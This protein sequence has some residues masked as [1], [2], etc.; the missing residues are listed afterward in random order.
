MKRILHAAA[1][2][3]LL[4][5][6]DV[7]AQGRGRQRGINVTRILERFDANED[8]KLTESEVTNASLWQRLVA[9][10]ED[11]DGAVTKKEMQSMASGRG[12]RGRGGEATWEFL[13]E[14][15]DGDKDGKVTLAEYTRSKDT[16]LRLDR[17]KD[18]VLSKQDWA[19]P[20]EGRSR[21]GGR[22][23]GRDARN[24]APE[25]GDVAPDF[26]LSFVSDANKTVKLSDYVGKKPVA[27]VFG[28]CT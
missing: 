10:D 5:S 8:G 23:R 26:T 24:S 27:L 9:V 20:S 14:K 16:F 13:A 15:Y 6:C 17:D 28:S 1:G 12:G 7:F 18:G 3:L 25:E 19:V 22:S 11:K 21:G 4:L 2:C